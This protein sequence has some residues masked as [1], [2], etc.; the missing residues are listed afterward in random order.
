MKTQSVA[1]THYTQDQ[2]ELRSVAEIFEQS[3]RDFRR[4]MELRDALTIRIARRTTQIIRFSMISIILLMGSVFY[5]LYLLNSNVTG[6]NQDMNHVSHH[7]ENISNN[8]V[9]VTDN[10]VSLK[11]SVDNV[12]YF[13]SVMPSVDESIHNIETQ[14][15]KMNVKLASIDDRMYNLSNHLDNVNQSVISID[16]NMLGLSADIA[17][18]NYQFS[19]LGYNVNRIAAP[20]K[21]FP[22]Q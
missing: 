8:L 13:L 3:L 11:H 6:V 19:G 18:L 17:S 9:L 4:A 15:A 16:N 22:F 2:T 14:M 12:N 20:M 5:L 1:K 7:M 21:F 10:I